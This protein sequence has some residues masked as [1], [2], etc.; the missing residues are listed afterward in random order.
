[1]KVGADPKLKIQGFKS[2]KSVSQIQNQKLRG[3]KFK[4][5]KY[6]AQIPKIQSFTAKPSSDTNSS[7][8]PSFK[9][10]KSKSFL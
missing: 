4:L 3:C 9:L 5:E 1:M 7:N 10:S 8:E 6:T 2:Q